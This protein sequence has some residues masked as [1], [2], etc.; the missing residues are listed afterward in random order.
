MAFP[1]KWTMFIFSFF[2]GCLMSFAMTAVDTGF[3]DNLNHRYIRGF[4]IGFGEAYPTAL[5]V[6]H[7]TRKLTELL[8]R[9]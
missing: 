4:G 1:K 8:P 3:T 9:D 6:A 2:M 5:L 7:L